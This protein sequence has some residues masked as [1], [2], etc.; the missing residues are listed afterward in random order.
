[1]GGLNIHASLLDHIMDVSL[2]RRQE[3]MGGIDTKFVV[4][5]VADIE[6]TGNITSLENPGDTVDIKHPWSPMNVAVA[7][8]AHCSLPRPTLIVRMPILV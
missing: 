6:S 5:A 1:M 4:A 7:A 8:L 3:Q 2:G